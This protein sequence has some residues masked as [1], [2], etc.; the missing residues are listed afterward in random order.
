MDQE[1]DISSGNGQEIGFKKR[2]K[3]RNLRQRSRSN[4]PNSA[5]DESNGV[6]S[7]VL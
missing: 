1:M 7:S 3:K 4:S 6:D 5:E 2:T